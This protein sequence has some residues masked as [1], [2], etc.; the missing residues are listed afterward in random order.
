MRKAVFK[1]ERVDIAIIGTGPAGLEAAL[2]AKNRNK[3]VL[4]FGSKNLSMKLAKAEQIN[5]YLGFPAISGAKL[6]EH[7]EEHLKDRGLEITDKKVTLIFA[8]GDYFSIQAD[9]DLYEAKTVILATGV[10]PAKTLPGET[11]YLGRGVSYC[12]TCDAA[13]YKGKTAVVVGYSKKEEAEAEFMTEYAA[14]TYYI[15][16]YKDEVNLSDKVEVIRSKPVSVS[17]GMKV[18]ALVTEDGEIKTDGIFILRDS[19]APTQLLAGLEMEGSHV[20]T[21]LKMETNI[22]GCFVAG[23]IAGTPYQYIKAA[24]QGNVAALSAVDFISKSGR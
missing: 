16:I 1:I 14:K 11:D 21:N 9:N 13:L 6:A 5:N 20:K 24:G 12:A 7:F 23:D 3:S 17:G 10:V 8:A 18:D 15:P 2:T 22:E 4:I 19:I